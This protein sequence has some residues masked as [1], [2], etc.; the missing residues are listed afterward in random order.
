MKK[1]QLFGRCGGASIFLC[2]ILSAV[3]LTEGILYYAARVRAYEADLQRCMRLQISQILANYNQSLLDH[4]GLYGVDASSVSSAVFN[5]CFSGSDDAVLTAEPSGILTSSDLKTG[6][7]DY[8]KIRMPAV[9]AGE[10]LTR[11]KG[12]IKEITDSQIFQKAQGSKS[13]EWLTY[14]KSFLDQK[15]KWGGVI[16]SA[17]SV[18]EAIDVTGKIKEIEEFSQSFQEVMQRNTTLYLQG[19]TADSSADD[20]M[21]PDNLSLIMG[22]ADNYMNFELPDVV[23]DIMVTEYAVSFFDSN[24]INEKDGDTEVPEANL[25]GVPFTDIHGSNRGDLEYILTGIDN[26]TASFGAAKIL[27]YDMRIIANFGAYL[28]DTEKMEKAKE[29]AE[30]LSTAIGV[31]SAGTISVDPAILQ[32]AVLY[33]WALGQGFADL[34]KL[35]EGDSVVLFDHSALS[36]Y[37]VLQDALL[38]DYRDY[39][40]FF[41]MAVPSEWKLSRIMTILNK[42]C[43]NDLYTGIRLS[44]DYRGSQFIMED[45]YDAYTSG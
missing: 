17:V 45:K 38:T 16:N 5:S 43:G 8:M 27:V 22:Y 1:H 6:I 36:D 31:V 40:G 25:L 21:N 42:D 9:A 41:L 23:D 44:V 30:I 35:A 12:V 24:I 34:M 37:E 10:I 2:I 20:I 13:S 11:L 32:F 19:G 33:V 28:V 7:S 15:D 4:Y 29:I 39:I 18:A 26:E 3:V 14:V